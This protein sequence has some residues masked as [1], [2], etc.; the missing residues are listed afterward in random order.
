MNA[1][2]FLEGK[3]NVVGVIICQPLN[4]KEFLNLFNIRMVVTIVHDAH[5]ELSS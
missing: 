3:N 2:S 1:F 5:N 4:N